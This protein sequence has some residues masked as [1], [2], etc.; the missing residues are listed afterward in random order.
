MKLIKVFPNWL[1][2][3]GI[4]SA[5]NNFNVP[6]KTDIEPDTLDVEYFGNISGEKTVSPLIKKLL[7]ADEVNT[8]TPERVSQLATTIYK[9]NGEKWGKLFATFDFEYNPIS[10]YDMTETETGSGSHSDSTTHGGTQTT[11]NTG[12]QETTHTGTSENTH[13][14]TQGTI[15]SSTVS[16][17]ATGN[18]DNSIYGFNSSDAQGDTAN[19]TTTTNESTASGST[20]RTDNLTDERTDNLTDERTD[21]LTQLRTDNLTDSNTGTDA[22]TRTLTRSGNIGV[23]TSQQ[24][25]QSER[26]LWMWNVFYSVIFPDIDRVLTIATY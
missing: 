26:E 18:T 23:T 20:T 14:G 7:K 25:I 6:W 17:E 12:T 11:T 16:G 21:N 3:S 2:G 19:E 5:L 24:M 10:N 8:L 1:T 22:H 4:F 9:I 13:T 15:D